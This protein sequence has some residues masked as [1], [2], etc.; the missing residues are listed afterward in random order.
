MKTICTIE[1]GIGRVIISKKDYYKCKKLN[2]DRRFK[3]VKEIYKKY[4][5]RLIKS[6]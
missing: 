5:K 2:F 1:T 6:L 3:V 4:K